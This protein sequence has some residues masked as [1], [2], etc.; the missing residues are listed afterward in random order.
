MPVQGVK[1]FTPEGKEF[2]VL[3]EEVYHAEVLDVE[4]KMQKKWQ[5]DEEESTLVFTFVVIEDGEHYGRRLWQYATPKLT[6]FKGGSNLYKVLTG[7]YGRQLTDDECASPEETCSDDAINDLI[8]RQ[9]RLGVGQKVKE[10][11][12]LKNI[13]N[14]FFKVKKGDELPSYVQAEKDADAPKV[15]PKA[16]TKKKAVKE[17]DEEEIVF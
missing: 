13:I 1:V 3:P 9:V 8:G 5:S 4:F 12:E 2:E 6:K 11:G 15:Q 16:S 7:L 17:D 10:N 14:S